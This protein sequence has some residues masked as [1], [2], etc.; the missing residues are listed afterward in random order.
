PGQELVDV[1]DV[2]AEAADSLA[3][4]PRQRAGAGVL[5]DAGKEVSTQERGR[6]LLRGHL[7][8]H[9]HQADAELGQGRR[10][11]QR[12]ER[13]RSEGRRG[14]AGERVEVLADEQRWH[15]GEEGVE[16]AHEQSAQQIEA[17]PK[18]GGLPDLAQAIH[19][20]S[21]S[22]PT[23]SRWAKC[24]R[25][26]RARSSRRPRS[27]IAPS[28]RMTIVSVRSTVA[29]RCAITIAVRPRRRRSSASSICTS[30]AG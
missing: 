14:L 30:V 25:G 27:R 1:V 26:S 3:G 8:G 6:N 9:A 2:V 13:R 18:A 29:R 22:R 12:E 19:A 20:S 24:E 21:A 17:K 11:E 28:S 7:E 16:A 23:R 15:E 5:E 4:G 10:D